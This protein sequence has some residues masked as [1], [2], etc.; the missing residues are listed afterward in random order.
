MELAA[1]DKAAFNNVSSALCNHNPVK[2]AVASAIK[3]ICQF[4]NVQDDGK[5]KQGKKAKAD[6][7]DGQP[8][9]KARKKEVEEDVTMAKLEETE[10]ESDFEG[11]ESDVDEPRPSV[12][13]PDSEAE[14]AEEAEFNKFDGLL[15]SSSED[16]DDAAKE[17][18]YSRFKGRETVNLD[19]ISLSGSGSEPDVEGDLSDS[20]E[21]ASP[22]PAKKAKE[23][24]AK[25]KKTTKIGPIRD[26]TFLPSLMGG[27]ISGSE[28]ASD[29]DVAPAKKRLGQRSRQAIYEKKFGSRANHLRKEKENGGRDAGWDMKRGAVEAG[30]QGRKGPWKKGIANPMARGHSSQE[31]SIK[32]EPKPT[33]RDDEGHLH[34]SWEAAKKAKEQKSAQFSGQKIVFD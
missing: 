27:Y 32:K 23:S 7:Q 2:Q 13:E 17:E 10:E 8:E 31:V 26:S 11:F 6:D 22:P 34:P 4:L 3:S 9:A 18:L 33:K 19:D 29:I 20:S 30:D 14:A 24:K 16:E 12:K 25:T 28:S 15:G 5:G 21:S 1:E